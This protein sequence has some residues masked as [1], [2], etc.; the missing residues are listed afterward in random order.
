[1]LL[2]TEV[3]KHNCHTTA[4][5]LRL[6]QQRLHH[7]SRENENPLALVT[8]VVFTYPKNETYQHGTEETW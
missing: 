4:P 6:S 3:F 8:P 7:G 2:Q 1:M 5:L